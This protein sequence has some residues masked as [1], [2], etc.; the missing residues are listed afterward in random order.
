MRAPAAALALALAAPAAAEPVAEPWAERVLLER[1]DPAAV[2]GRLDA[3]ALAALRATGERLFV[4]RF[5]EADG[6]G[7]PFATQA[8]VPTA[9]RRAPENAFF[10]SAGLDANAC[11]GCHNQPAT[12]GAGDFV[13]NV[14]VSEGFESAD[15]DSL[16]PQFSNERG[17]NHLFG[18]G[19]I[20]LLAR[21]MTAE[22]HAVRRA[23]LAEARA[24]GAPVTAALAAKGVGFGA[25]TA[26]PDGMLDLG[27]VE[28][29]DDDLVIRPFS[30]KGVM[31]SLRQ[32]TVNALNHHHGIQADERFGPRWTGTRDHDGDGV[33][34]E[35][36]AGEISA[37]VAWQAGLAPPA[38]ETPADAAWRAAARRGDALFDGLGCQACHRRAL[39]L[40]SLEFADPGPL[41]MAGTLRAG[42]TPHGA[43]YDLALMAWAERLPRDADGRILVPLFGDL[44]RHVIADRQVATLGNELLAQRFVERNVFMTAELWGVAETAPYGHRNDLTTLDAVIRAHGGAARAARDAYVAAAETDRRALIAF[45]RTLVIAP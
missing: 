24:G 23:A 30:Q 33:D 6:V 44:K 22:L 15:F 4:G 13:A 2:A 41:D 32:F 8:I 3:A 39:P 19:L 29:V 27:A 7:R 25:V 14:F 40:D 16:D 18:A 45:L 21:E 35:I 34:D 11:S 36:G 28:G 42:E 12:G 37:L 20:E 31:T 10:R 38:V 43:V 9:R 26:H 1:V 17:T 5:T